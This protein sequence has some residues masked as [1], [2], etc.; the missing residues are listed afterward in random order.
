MVAVKKRYL[1]PGPQF[2][3]QN[4]Y[5]KCCLVPVGEYAKLEGKAL[6]VRRD[7][8]LWVKYT[9]TSNVKLKKVTNIITL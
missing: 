7:S 4:K 6:R 8:D 2:I 5:C 9:V 1:Q 3:T